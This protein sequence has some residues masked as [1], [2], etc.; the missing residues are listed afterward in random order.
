M[1]PMDGLAFDQL[2]EEDI[3]GD[4]LEAW[5][6]ESVLMK[7]SFRNA[8]LIGGLI[9]RRFPGEKKSGRQVTFSA[10]LIYDVLRRHQ[11]D[12][13]LLQ[14]ARMDA[15]SGLLDVGRIGDFLAR[16][17]TRIRLKRLDHV[18]PFAVPTLMEIGRE[19]APGYSASEMAL[20]EASALIAEAMG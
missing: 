7:R 9:E 1:K 20:E 14:C 12:H 19:R 4:D 3:L 15:A 5:L 17:K 11:P 6:E 13:L 2:F 16:V 10:D 8:A 18:S